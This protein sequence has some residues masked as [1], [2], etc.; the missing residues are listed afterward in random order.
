MQGKSSA[1]KIYTAFFWR[2]PTGVMR[3]AAGAKAVRK[4][5]MK[6]VFVY[7]QLFL[8]IWAPRA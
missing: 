6:F 1:E 7:E 5:L 2:L 3:K 4:S 8:R